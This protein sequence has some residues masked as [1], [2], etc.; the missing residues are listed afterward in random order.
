MRQFVCPIWALNLKTQ[1][2]RKTKLVTGM[3]LSSLK[4]HRSGL[5]SRSAIGGRLHNMSALGWQILLVIVINRNQVCYHFG[6]PAPCPTVQ[7]A[8]G[9]IEVVDS[10]VYLGSMIDSS[11]GSR[12]EILRRIGLARTCMQQ[13]EKRIWKSGIRLDTKIRLCQTYIVPV[14]L[15]GCE[16]WTTTKYLC[17]R[18]DA[19]DMW[20]LRKILR[21]PYTPDGSVSSVTSPA[22][23]LTKITIV[24]LLLRYTSLLRWL[25][26]MEADLRPLNIGLSSAWRKASGRADWHHIVDTATLWK[27]TP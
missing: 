14:V 23:L 17:A 16:T 7:V 21:I 25:R 3:L 15:Y 6:N 1:N 24:P 26:S 4:G 2:H 13:L 18:L 10:F 9:L 20:A 5:V 22:A 27:S 8:D 12:G 11:G 19:F